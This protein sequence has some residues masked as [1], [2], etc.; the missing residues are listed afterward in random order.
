MAT[1]E[2]KDVSLN[3]RIPKYYF[4]IL[5]KRVGELNLSQAEYVRTL[6]SLEARLGLLGNKDAGFLEF[7]NVEE[8]IKEINESLSL[9]EKLSEIQ[10]KLDTRI[11]RMSW[12]K[13]SLKE[14]LKDKQKKK[15]SKKAKV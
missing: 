4:D 2:T 11:N 6:L 1:I 9:R 13:T 10:F 14:T 15:R 7:E 5:L 3:V 8:L 12:L